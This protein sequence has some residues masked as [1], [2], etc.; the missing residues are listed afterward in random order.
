[1]ADSEPRNENGTFKRA[2]M[3]Q[4]FK[5]ATKKMLRPKIDLFTSRGHNKLKI[6]FFML[7]RSFGF[8]S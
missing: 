4:I 8:N 7:Q 2:L 5:L 1:M 3:D 6:F